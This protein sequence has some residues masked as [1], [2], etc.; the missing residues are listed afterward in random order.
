LISFH[1]A[2]SSYHVDGDNGDV[3]AMCEATSPPK[4]IGLMVMCIADLVLVPLATVS[5]PHVLGEHGNSVVAKVAKVV[6]V[7]QDTSFTVGT[8]WIVFLMAL[9]VGLVG[10]CGWVIFRETDNPYNGGDSNYASSRV[11]SVGQIV[12][13]GL[14]FVLVPVAISQ[15]VAVMP[16]DGEGHSTVFPASVSC[17]SSEHLTYCALGALA[18]C[19]VLIPLHRFGVMRLRNLSSESW[20][21]NTPRDRHATVGPLFLMTLFFSRLVKLCVTPVL[22]ACINPS[23]PWLVVTALGIPVL[24]DALVIAQLFCFRFPSVSIPLLF[25]YLKHLYRMLFVLDLG[26]ALVVSWRGSLLSNSASLEAAWWVLY[27]ICI[28]SPLICMMWSDRCAPMRFCVSGAS[29]GDGAG[30][31]DED[32]LFEGDV[33]PVF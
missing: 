29:D 6:L 21:A 13:V 8:F 32:A 23:S 9:L 7:T 10:Y 5:A 27:A 26:V 33:R 31:V 30:Y 20:I 25:R 16:C 1:D 24:M 12:V 19:L 28:S 4:R 2:T 11:S 18:L 17:R 22:A 3:K 14:F 15:A